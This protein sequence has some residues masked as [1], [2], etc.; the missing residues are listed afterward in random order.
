MFLLGRMAEE[1]PGQLHAIVRAG[2]L[3]HIVSNIFSDNKHLSHDSFFLLLEIAD[4]GDYH[5][6]ITATDLFSRLMEA[7]SQNLKL[8]P[9][10]LDPLCSIFTNNLTAEDF[11]TLFSCLLKGLVLADDFSP[12]ATICG[13]FHH[14][15]SLRDLSSLISQATQETHAVPRILELLQSEKKE[16]LMTEYQS[17]LYELIVQNSSLPPVDNMI[18]TE[19][20]KFLLTS[21][22]SH[23]KVRFLCPCFSTIVLACPDLNSLIGSGLIP[24]ILNLRPKLEEDTVS[25]VL[26]VL[27]I[28]SHALLLEETP[29]LLLDHLVDSGLFSYF[30][31]LLRTQ[32]LSQNS[33]PTQ[34]D[35]ERIEED[36]KGRLHHKPFIPFTEV[37]HLSQ[38]ILDLD[39]KYLD[40]IK[41]TK[42]FTRPFQN[43]LLGAEV[44][45]KDEKPAERRLQKK[46]RGSQKSEEEES[47]EVNEGSRRST[48]SSSKRVR[49][50]E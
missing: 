39:Q 3:P 4:F 15:L 17:I 7:C 34:A 19:F 44:T 1:I 13:I 26:C 49:D 45:D 27:K 22:S 11:T 14:F 12:K 41:M 33:L 48:R 47:Q 2:F 6:L 38:Q 35:F 21:T 43:L 50:H 16:T 30:L 9:R 46:R 36:K 8:I 20:T 32:Q 10:L 28:T 25:V 23:R 18:L 40:A 31:Y 24:A 5:Q 42:K 29:H 37:I